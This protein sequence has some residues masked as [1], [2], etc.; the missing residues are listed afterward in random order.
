[1]NSPLSA[2]IHLHAQA[3]D[4][5]PRSEFLLQDNST[6]KHNVH[7][8]YCHVLLSVQYSSTVYYLNGVWSTVVLGTSTQQYYWYEH[9]L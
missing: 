6:R 2:D 1:M 4:D 9:S 3:H 8:V 7:I 5:R